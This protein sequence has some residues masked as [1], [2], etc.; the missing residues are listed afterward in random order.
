MD[1][2]ED[3]YNM[4]LG[5]SITT[6]DGLTMNKVVRTF[7]GK[8]IGTNLFRGSKPINAVWETPYIVVVGVTTYDEI[9]RASS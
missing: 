3:I 2:N 4:S 5:K 6:K 8:K 7:T 1:E 9:G